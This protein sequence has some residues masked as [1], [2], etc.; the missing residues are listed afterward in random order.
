MQHSPHRF[1]QQI[2]TVDTFNEQIVIEIFCVPELI[3]AMTPQLNRSCLP[4]SITSFIF[5]ITFR[6]M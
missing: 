5:H 3:L 4:I 2:I 1:K 6:P